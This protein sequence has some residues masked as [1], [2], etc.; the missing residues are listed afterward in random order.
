MKLLPFSALFVSLSFVVAQDEA[1][2]PVNQATALKAGPDQLVELL[3]DQSEAGIDQAAN[4]YATAKRIETE[5]KLAAKD[6]SLVIALGDIRSAL[7]K[8]NLECS[9][10][11]YILTG[12]GTMWSHGSVRAQVTIED[13]LAKFATRLP[14]KSQDMTESKAWK[15]LKSKASS[16]KLSKDMADS[17]PE[18]SKNWAKQKETLATALEELGWM[19]NT[20]PADDAAPLMSFLTDCIDEVVTAAKEL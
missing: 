8:W 20:M 11:G 1:T 6:L 13:L 5:S 9:A 17:D 2:K 7:Q 14:L 12:G 19:I 3:G 18:A 15:A 10:A 16:L 4:L